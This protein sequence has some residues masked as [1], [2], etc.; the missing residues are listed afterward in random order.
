MDSPTPQRKRII[1]Y[2]LNSYLFFLFCVNW[3]CERVIPWAVCF[4]LNLLKIV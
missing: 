1:I 2:K 4:N 3:C